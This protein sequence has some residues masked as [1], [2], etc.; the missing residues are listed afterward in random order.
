MK[1][2][3]L[4]QSFRTYLEQIEFPVIIQFH[5]EYEFMYYA[6]NANEMGK[7]FLKVLKDRLDWFY[8]DKLSE[9]SPLTMEE[10]D[11]LP[12]CYK[13]D[14]LEKRKKF[15]K[16]D[17]EVNENNRILKLAHEAVIEECAEKA[18]E[19]IESKINDEYGNFEIISIKD[20]RL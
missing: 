4:P 6:S 15:L 5:D 11:K 7:V 12:E 16:R 10:I 17:K 13:V 18:W 3:N 1:I 14:A 2:K 20:I 19:C 8:E 9:S